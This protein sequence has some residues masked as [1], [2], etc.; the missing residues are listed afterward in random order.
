MLLKFVWFQNS[1]SS[2]HG[3]GFF[4]KPGLAQPNAGLRDGQRGER[5]GCFAIRGSAGGANSRER[6]WVVAVNRGKNNAKH[7]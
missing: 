5:E 7:A 1:R 4:L 3:A 6:G 2:D